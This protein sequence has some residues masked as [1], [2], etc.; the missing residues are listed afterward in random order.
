MAFFDIVRARSGGGASRAPLVALAQEA[1]YSASAAEAALLA[2]APVYGVPKEQLTPAFCGDDFLTFC[3][4]RCAGDDEEHPGQART[5][6]AL[7]PPCTSL[8][9]RRPGRASS[10]RPA[11]RT[12]GAAT[13][14]AHRGARQ[15]AAAPARAAAAGVAPCGHSC[16]APAGRAR[17][18]VR[19]P[20][21]VGR[22]PAPRTHPAARSLVAFRR[23]NSSGC[24]AASGA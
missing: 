12:A 10:G 4:S 14:A 2:F 1:G 19:V 8:S 9:W 13:T 6:L 23:A 16:G 5:L 3:A 7:L 24:A 18:S 15:A 11:P 20:R 17:V 22:P 21:R